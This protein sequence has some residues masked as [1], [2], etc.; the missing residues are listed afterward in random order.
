MNYQYT[1][2]NT[3]ILLGL[4]RLRA[5]S[6]ELDNLPDVCQKTPSCSA[7]AR[8]A[9]ALPM[10]LRRQVDGSNAVGIGAISG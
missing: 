6:R 4:R 10:P 9:V 1:V 7:H 8:V 5:D 2:R 3:V